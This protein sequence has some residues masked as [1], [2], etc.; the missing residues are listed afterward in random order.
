M[1]TDLGTQWG[2]VCRKGCNWVGVLNM[3]KEMSW[4]LGVLQETGLA[5]DLTVPQSGA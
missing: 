5:P 4:G 1:V 3:P 2:Q